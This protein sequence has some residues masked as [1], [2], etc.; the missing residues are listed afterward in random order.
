[1]QVVKQLGRYLGP[2]KFFTL[3]APILMVL[4]VTMDFNPTNHYATYD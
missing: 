3:V 4:E 1:M 2:Y